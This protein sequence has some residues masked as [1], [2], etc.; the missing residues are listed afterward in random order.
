MWDM[1]HGACIHQ[2]QYTG[3][4]RLLAKA[5]IV[6]QGALCTSLRFLAFNLEI[7]VYIILYTSIYHVLSSRTFVGRAYNILC[8]FFWFSPVPGVPPR[9]QKGANP[10]ETA[11]LPRTLGTNLFE[12]LAAVAFLIFDLLNPF[13]A[14][15]LLYTFLRFS[16]WLGSIQK[17]KVM[18]SGKASSLN[19]LNSFLQSQ[20]SMIVLSSSFQPGWLQQSHA[21]S[22]HTASPGQSLPGIVIVEKGGRNQTGPQLTETP[23][24]VK[25][26][27][28]EAR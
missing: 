25:T 8:G 17:Q 15:V 18:A 1:V 3:L 7:D 20:H 11:I 13:A 9:D 23:N 28:N 26:K 27:C 16:R 21:M 19:G 12:S 6:R 4:Q 10:P 5:N 22:A 2:T 24:S 14:G